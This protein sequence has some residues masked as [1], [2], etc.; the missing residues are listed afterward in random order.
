[1][2]R[3]IDD[4]AASGWV[5]DPDT[6]YW[7]WGG[8]GSGSGGGGGGSFP[9]APLDGKQ[10]GRQN[11]GWTEIV[12]GGGGGTVTTSDVQLTNP[13]AF[14]PGGLATQEDANTFFAGEVEKII[15]D[16]PADSGIYGRQN[17]VWVEVPAGGDGSGGY[18]PRITNTQISNWDTAYGWGDHNGKGYLTSAS[19]NGYATESWVTSKGYLT[20]ASLNGYATQTWVSQNY[21]PKGSYISTESDPTVPAYVKSI[22]QAD[23][24]KWNNPPAGGGFN[25]T[26]NGPHVTFTCTDTTSV[27]RLDGPNC[28]IKMSGTG[29][30][31]KYIRLSQGKIE[32]LKGDYSAALLSIDDAGLVKTNNNFG[33][34]SFTS[35]VNGATLLTMY[36]NA[37]SN[38]GSL[39]AGLYFS[40]SASVPTIT[41]CI[42]DSFVETDNKIALGN[43]Q[44]RFS[45]VF[46]VGG[47]DSSRRHTQNDGEAVLSVGD[48]IEVF[49]S[50]REAT[51]EEKTMEGLRDAIGNCVGGIVERLEAIQ[52]ATDEQTSR[53]LEMHAENND[54]PLPPFTLTPELPPLEIN[55]D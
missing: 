16:A 23:I 48:L 41:P 38:S 24:N 20:S 46:S 7:N 22:S 2:N 6:G 43:P 27:L 44:K 50:L 19:L 29:S 45:K 51:K 18:D 21:Q 3:V 55:E 4:P 34:T 49:E 14:A 33:A 1:M 5:L 47:V 35:T 53:E 9:E 12:G 31:G 52:A 39:G 42:G 28:G 15:A 30:T 26:Y 25:G 37:I 13:T 10:Y 36:G 8:S 40:N 17:N 54:E 32:F 11:A